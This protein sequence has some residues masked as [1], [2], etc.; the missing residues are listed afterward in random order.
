VF[1]TGSY[2]AKFLGDFMKLIGVE[3]KGKTII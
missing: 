2:L 1:E 3:E